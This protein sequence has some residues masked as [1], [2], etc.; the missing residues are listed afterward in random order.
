V[1]SEIARYAVRC[2][3]ASNVCQLREPNRSPL[4]VD[5]QQ[6]VD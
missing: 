4:S 2:S 6:I 3:V 1:P 5:E